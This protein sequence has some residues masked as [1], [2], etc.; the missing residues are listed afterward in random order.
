MKR[1]FLVVFAILIF[2]LCFGQDDPLFEV[3]D[4]STT[5]FSVTPTGIKILEM[6]FKVVAADHK[7]ELYDE[8]GKKLFYASPENARFIF[9][10]TNSDVDRG[11]FAISTVASGDPTDD[12]G[13]NYFDITPENYFIGHDA[14]SS[15]SE[16][17]YNTFIG[18]N[19]GKN[20]EGTVSADTTGSNN[21][22]IGYES[23]LNNQ[24]GVNNVFIGYQ[25]GKNNVGIGSYT[26]DHN[27]F[28]G[29]KSGMK[30]NSAGESGQSNV[31]IG[32]LCG[33][34][35]TSGRW[36]VF[37]GT[38]TGQVNQT[39]YF[40]TFVGAQAGKG[41]LLGDGN[42]NTLIG[43]M[44]G[45][46]ERSDHNTY[47]GYRSGFSHQTGGQNTLIGMSTLHN[48][49]SGSRNV[50]LGH[51]AGFNNTSG[52]DNVFIG[53]NAGADEM[54]SDKL[55]IEN[56]NS[57]TPLI[58]GDFANDEVTIN[59]DL[60]ANNLTVDTVNASTV[61][62]NTVTATIKLTTGTFFPP[63]PTEGQ[64]FYS[65]MNHKLYVRTNTGWQALW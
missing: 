11:G 46:Y 26:G 6:E 13:I 24:E 61:T 22:F 23:G 3:K 1:I 45:H 30:N 27:V 5:I 4:G 63:T 34:E 9:H 32:K 31:F 58:H 55:Y 7:L 19:S 65:S 59:G 51:G 57:D 15:I 33:Y 36:N 48:N 52:S 38:E 28:I 53:Y 60:E 21:L 54:G 29:Y 17:L 43:Y 62:A 40:N 49:Y 2:G 18:Y 39:G 42:Y 64:L 10:P 20:T 12:D 41:N 56:S 14:G 8:D 35:N 16:G 50:A 47:L 25:A 44:S 37:I